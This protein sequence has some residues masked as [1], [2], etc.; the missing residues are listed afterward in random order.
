MNAPV[1]IEAA[2]N[3]LTTKARNPYVPVTTEEL[4]AEA[5]AC[6]DAGA[7]IIHN[8]IGNTPMSGA[9]SA[10]H[11]AAVWTEVLGRR[12]EALWYP[13]VS[14]G[15]VANRY[16]HIAPLAAAGLLRMSLSDPGSVNLGRMVNGLPAG[17]TPYT[18]SFDEIAHQFALCEEY[19]LGVSIAVYE[20][21]FL[22]TVLAYH[23]AG[24]LPSGAFV[25]L[26]FS[27]DRGLT[28]TAFG[29]PPTPTALAS[30]LELL[31][32]TGLAWAVSAA[33]GDVVRTDLCA[34]ALAAG[35]HLHIGLEFYNGDRTPTNLELI[36]EAVT[37][38]VASGRPV[39]SSAEAAAILGLPDRPLVISKNSSRRDPA[40]W[41]T[42]VR[43]EEGLPARLVGSDN[44]F[45][46]RSA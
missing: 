25:K 3:G 20:P 37:A 43:P 7:A 33:G 19:R 27:T 46:S 4:I 11:Y 21:G 22:R 14:F 36:E 17:A 40:A 28:G 6:L 31:D 35:G 9:E 15:P 30:Y 13:T 41:S 24:R 45:P 5:V 1:I 39:A 44:Q 34:A 32:G 38:C 10:Q 16:D 8:H 42:E 2:I 26:Y 18:N 29:L 23:H 12:P